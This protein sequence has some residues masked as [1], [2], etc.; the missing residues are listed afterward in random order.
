MAERHLLS[1]KTRHQELWEHQ[2]LTNLQELVIGEE[3]Q[4][5]RQWCESEEN[6]G[7]LTH[8]NST[9]KNIKALNVDNI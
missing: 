1:Q 9:Q 2:L 5:L 7:K 6:K 4:E 8:I 3:D